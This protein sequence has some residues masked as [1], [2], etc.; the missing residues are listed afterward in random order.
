M[1]I[2]YTESL[3]GITPD[4][5]EGFFRGWKTPHTP[6]THLQI[7]RGSSHVVIALNSARGKVIGYV[8][9]LSDGIQAAFIPLLEVLPDYQH[10]GIGTELMK[11]M[12]KTL[13]SIPA[14]DLICDRHL[15][16]FYS[17]FGMQPAIGMVI[18]NY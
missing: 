11:R 10:Q 1:M 13:D 18:R 16:K 4:M 15:Q 14:I 5:L 12:L 2:E 17:R 6:E 8:A 7:L 3:D 9:A